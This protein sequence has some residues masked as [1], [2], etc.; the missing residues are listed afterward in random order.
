MKSRSRVDQV[1]ASHRPSVI[2]HA[3]EH[4]PLMEVEN[5]REAVLN[6]ALGT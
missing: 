6:N 2:S 3:A 1:V 4:V 5:A